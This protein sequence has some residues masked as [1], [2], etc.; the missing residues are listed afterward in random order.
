[1]SLVSSKF[2]FFFFFFCL[3]K[4]KRV[5]VQETSGKGSA[6]VHWE[7]LDDRGLCSPLYILPHV[8]GNAWTLSRSSNRP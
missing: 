2:F 4:Q 1:M 8:Q 3:F 7:S 6:V 5:T